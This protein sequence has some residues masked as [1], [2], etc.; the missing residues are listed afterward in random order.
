MLPAFPGKLL[1]GF[2]VLAKLLKL[3]CDKFSFTNSLSLYIPELSEKRNA[4]TEF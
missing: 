2:D 4:K 1:V 3:F